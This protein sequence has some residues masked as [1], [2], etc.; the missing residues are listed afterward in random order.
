MFIKNIEIWVAKDAQKPDFL[1]KRMS[2]DL[3]LYTI[4]KLRLRASKWCATRL[5]DF[6][7]R[8]EGITYM[9]LESCGQ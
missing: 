7:G 6:F 2:P 8:N 5:W 4:W 3:L 9:C 1:K